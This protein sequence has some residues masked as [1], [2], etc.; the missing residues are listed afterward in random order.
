MRV[1]QIKMNN[2][3]FKDSF[4][5]QRSILLITG[6]LIKAEKKF[7]IT[8]EGMSKQPLETNSRMPDNITTNHIK[9]YQNFLSQILGK[10][11]KWKWK[12]KKQC[13]EAMTGVIASV[14]Q[15]KRQAMTMQLPQMHP[16]HF[17]P[18]HQAGTIQLPTTM[19]VES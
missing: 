11:K 19:P 9:Q 1:S 8:Q 7:L 10:W 16:P 3:Y 12:I 15:Q 18:S 6:E 5:T 14:N 4:R 2:L 17:V 13:P